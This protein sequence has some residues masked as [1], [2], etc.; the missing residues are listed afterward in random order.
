MRFALKEAGIDIPSIALVEELTNLVIDERSDARD[1]AAHLLEVVLE[2]GLEDTFT[3][4]QLEQLAYAIR[5]T[6]LDEDGNRQMA[7][8]DTDPESV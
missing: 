8:P 1:G 2:R 4:E 3:P 5:F 6:Y 7:F